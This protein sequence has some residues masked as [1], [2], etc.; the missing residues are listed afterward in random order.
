M[1]IVEKIENTTFKV[2]TNII[3]GSIILTHLIT[4]FGIEIMNPTT[5]I[6]YTK[7]GMFSKFISSKALSLKEDAWKEE[8]LFLCTR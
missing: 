7:L 4:L 1:K 3:I 2:S 5:L 6:M 8:R